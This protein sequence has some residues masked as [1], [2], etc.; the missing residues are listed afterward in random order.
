M[1]LAF[2]II[3]LFFCQPVFGQ[4]EAAIGDTIEM[5]KEVRKDYIN[6][7]I[8]GKVIKIN[9]VKYLI[10]DKI[11]KS[12]EYVL[13]KAGD[14][15]EVAEEPMD[16][17]E[18]YFIGYGENRRLYI[19][20]HLIV[21]FGNDEIVRY[22]IHSKGR[23]TVT[24]LFQNA[25]LEGFIDLEENKRYYYL[26]GNPERIN[27]IEYNNEEVK[28]KVFNEY[29]ES[30][31]ERKNFKFSIIDLE[32]DIMNPIG[33]LDP[34]LA[35][36]KKQGTGFLINNDGYIITNFHVVEDASKVKVTGIKG[37]FSTSFEA[38]VVGIDRRNDLA[39]LRV[40][41]KLFSFSNPPYTLRDSKEVKKAERV[42]ALGYPI[43][44]ALGKEVKITDGL[45]NSLTGFK[46]SISEFQISVPVQAGN[47]GG[48][49]FDSNG[50]LVGVISAKIVSNSVDQVGYAIKSDYLAFFLDQVGEIGFNSNPN[51]L[52]GKELS[53][54]VE[55]I[56]DFVYIIESE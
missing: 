47:S 51:Q 7:H 31:E 11:R 15:K 10:L 40:E 55:L 23:L 44:S 38:T 3:T 36:E 21:T 19:N 52:T 33:K 28:K 27:G 48:P 12:A 49:L 18:I 56:S 39:L 35:N 8:E 41:S 16:H 1:K 45:I 5:T 46:S 14:A 29:K 4:I 25:R 26:G 9:D 32:E 42:Y 37:D 2:L 34:S 17:A 24:Y 43:E 50:E 53:E 20:D 22:K 13:L 6:D 30:L 54:Q